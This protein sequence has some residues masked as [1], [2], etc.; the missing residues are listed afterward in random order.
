[1]THEDRK[2]RVT[3][4]GIQGKPLQS[5]F[6]GSPV[7][8]E[9]SQEPGYKRPLTLSWDGQEAAVSEVISRWDDWGFGATPPKRR[10]WWQRRHRTYYRVKTADGRTF[11]L[12]YDR[13]R[14]EWFL[15]REILGS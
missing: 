1:M 9:Y 2:D 8:V 4:S 3:G 6:I 15:T 5:R 7:K 12:Y 10:H 13:S 11:E 14:R